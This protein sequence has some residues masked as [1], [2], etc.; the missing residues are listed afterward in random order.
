MFIIYSVRFSILYKNCKSRNIFNCSNNSLLV[1]S[2]IEFKNNCLREYNSQLSAVCLPVQV[3][4]L[5]LVKFMLLNKMLNLQN[6]SEE[7]KMPNIHGWICTVVSRFRF[8]I[9]H[10]TKH[11]SS[12]FTKN[13]S[14]LQ[15]L[16]NDGLPVT[17]V[18]N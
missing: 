10:Q 11:L 13:L 8:H 12:M 6:V 7:R 18:K 2:L 3:S 9:R 15:S 4:H 14:I 16:W 1:C 5:F 17:N